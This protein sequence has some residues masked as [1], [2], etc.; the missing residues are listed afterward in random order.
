MAEDYQSNYN[1]DTIAKAVHV[2]YSYGF[3]A[4]SVGAS[5]GGPRYYEDCS[6]TSGKAGIAGF[7]IIH[8]V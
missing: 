6:I 1:L 4:S 8:Q 5:N 2:D 3:K 7:Q